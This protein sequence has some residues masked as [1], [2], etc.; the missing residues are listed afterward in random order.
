[1]RKHLKNSSFQKETSP[2]IPPTQYTFYNTTTKK[3][4]EIEFYDHMVP[5][6]N[7]GLNEK[8]LA[9]NLKVL[10]N[11]QPISLGKTRGKNYLWTNR[12]YGVLL[13]NHRPEKP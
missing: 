8:V 9:S 10:L 11:F 2:K 6:K 5:W 1:M 4:G 7:F 3:Q 13:K 12:G